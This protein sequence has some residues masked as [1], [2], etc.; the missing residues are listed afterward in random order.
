MCSCHTRVEEKAA[1][2]ALSFGAIICGDL[3]SGTADEIASAT[4]L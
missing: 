3:A 1:T 2:A 4:R